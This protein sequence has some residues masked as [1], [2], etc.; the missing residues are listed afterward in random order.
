LVEPQFEKINF[1]PYLK[2][3]LEYFDQQFKSK[4][5]NVNLQ[6][7][8][9]EQNDEIWVDKEMMTTALY[10]LI[11]N[12]LKYTPNNGTIAIRAFI[13]HI[14]GSRKTRKKDKKHPQVNEVLNIEINDNGIGIPAEEIPNVFN[15]FYQASNHGSIGQAGS[16]IGLSIVKEYIDLH[17][18][19]IT[20]NSQQGKGTTFL[21][22][23]PLGSKHI[24][25][26]QLKTNTPVIVEPIAEIKPVVEQEEPVEPLND[27]ESGDQRPMLLIAE[28]DHEMLNFLVQ[29]M[30]E[31]Y[32]IITAVMGNKPGQKS[33]V[34]CLTL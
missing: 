34:S 15:R 2:D 1:I 20:V 17:K 26:H 6:L 24:G 30:S 12:A 14:E 21:I 22:Q 33:S 7:D 28:D 16:G 9:S 4:E 31:K 8:I 32:R 3:I 10:N 11:S 29:N 19:N 13:S 5:I 27:F 18:G 25:Q 23:L